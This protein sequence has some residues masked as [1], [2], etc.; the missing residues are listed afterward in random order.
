MTTQSEAPAK[1]GGM[2]PLKEKISFGFAEFGS[3][4]VWN[5]VGSYLLLFYTDVALIPAVVAGNI[6]LVARV[7]DGIQDLAFGYIAERTKSRWGRFRPYVIFGAPVLSISLILAFWMPFGGS[8]TGVKVAWA[9]IT[10]VLLCFVYTVANMSYG[11]LAGVMTTDSGERVTLN[12]I[13]SIGS[14]IAQN[15]MNVVTPLLL[16]FFAASEIAKDKGGDARSY[17]LTM[18]VF[19]CIALPAFLV[20]GFNVRERITLT[21]E[22]QKV[23]FGATVK[24]VVSNGQLLVIFFML[25]VNLIGL[26]GRLGVMYFYCIYILGNPVLMAPVMLAFSLGST[27]GQ[28]LLPPP[29]PS[30]WASGTCSWRPCS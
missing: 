5:T 4:F 14:M 13:R 27:A 1:K 29:S 25:L 3:Q 8:G 11:S 22:Q 24:A 21:P 12:W 30:S 16:V 19:A 23:S 28:V 6:L 7:L 18:V 17:L 10:Y 15:V 2:V 26:F 20:T 9:G